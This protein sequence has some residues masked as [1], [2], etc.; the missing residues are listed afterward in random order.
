MT[1]AM[2]DQQAAVLRSRIGRAA[3]YAER[4]RNVADLA[5]IESELQT[6]ENATRR[7]AQ[8]EHGGVKLCKRVADLPGKD[9]HG[10]EHWWLQTARKEAGMGPTTGNVPGH[11][12][13]L[14]E[15]WATQL[16]DHSR[17]PKTNCEP[18]DKVVD[19][20]CVDRELQL[21]ATT[22]N[23]TPGLNDCHSVVKRIIDKCHDEAVTKALE[24]DTARRL[25]DADAGAP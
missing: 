8:Q 2:L 4:E 5:T 24:A 22:G 23:W 20:D 13:S 7:A 19:E 17:E 21:G 6:R 25:R 18:V 16:V 3:S 10:A 12:E 14:P 15:T 11:G 9:I 1:D